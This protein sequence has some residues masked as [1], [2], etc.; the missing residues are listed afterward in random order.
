MLHLHLYGRA[1][2]K[3]VYV[4]PRGILWLFLVV[5]EGGGGGAEGG[6]GTR[7]EGNDRDKHETAQMRSMI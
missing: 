5:V 3:G 7:N 2:W 6:G 4:G 1:L